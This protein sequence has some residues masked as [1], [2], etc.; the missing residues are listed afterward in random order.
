MITGLRN[1]SGIDHVPYICTEELSPQ[2][3]VLGTDAQW[4]YL[5]A[6]EDDRLRVL[7]TMSIGTGRDFAK[8]K[9][10][11]EHVQKGRITKAM[12]KSTGKKE[13]SNEIIR[14]ANLMG[15]DPTVFPRPKAWANPKRLTWM[16]DNK[17]GAAEEE[18]MVGEFE[19]YL[20]MKDDEA[21]DDIIPGS[22]IRKAD[23]YKMRLYEAVF[24]EALRDAFLRR[25][26]SLSRLQLDARNSVEERVVP[27]HE[28]VC[29]KHN[30]ETWIPLSKNFPFFHH[31][32]TESFYLPKEQD[33]TPE[34][35]KRLLVEVRGRL[36]QV[37]QNWKTSG[38]GKMNMTNPGKVIKVRGVND[39][40]YDSN[41]EDEDD[42]I[43]V[44][45]DRWQFAQNCGM[46]LGYFWCLCELH[47][48]TDECLQRCEGAGVTMDNIRATSVGGGVGTPK[49]VDTN[50][51]SNV[52]SL[53][54]KQ[55]A[56]NQKLSLY[57]IETNEASDEL[58]QLKSQ[59]QF[60]KAERYQAQQWKATT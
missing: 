18:W 41:D 37:I 52:L 35:V 26:D 3:E 58:S 2:S 8:D 28:L 57:N 44:D 47:E 9:R 31:E 20:K 17:I 30:D 12:L 40:I 11:M 59:I 43:F 21:A 46:H 1:P 36:N 38:N 23:R 49:K 22:N 55:M 16:M 54:T 5:E 25:N 4:F 53:I 33:L 32:L 15:I 14:R 45:D 50:G 34:Q 56:N 6:E 10:L 48:L 51:Y 7:L 60:L 19:S 13:F 39:G 42:V 24:L 29:N 27:F